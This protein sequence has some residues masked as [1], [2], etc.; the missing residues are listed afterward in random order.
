MLKRYSLEELKLPE[1]TPAPVTEPTIDIHEQEPQIHQ[2]SETVIENI[3]IPDMNKKPPKVYDFD[4]KLKTAHRGSF[5]FMLL[6]C[7]YEA[8]VVQAEVRRLQKLAREQAEA[9]EKSNKLIAKQ[10]SGEI[11]STRRSTRDPS[12]P[13]S[14]RRGSGS[15]NG[16]G[17]EDSSN[18]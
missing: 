10:H 1:V 2:A 12:P 11:N 9:A 13:S 18:L 5:I 14:S 7:K 3:D 17:A 16:V 6:Y 4:P 15:T 8:Y